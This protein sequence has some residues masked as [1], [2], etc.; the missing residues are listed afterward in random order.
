MPLMQLQ[1]KLQKATEITYLEANKEL[2]SKNEVRTKVRL[3]FWRWN[4]SMKGKYHVFIGYKQRNKVCL[5]Y[6]ECK[7][8]KDRY[9][10]SI[11]KL[12]C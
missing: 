11:Y 7:P 6:L 8:Q 10:W 12:K 4:D 3:M 2:R 5:V 1:V 9:G